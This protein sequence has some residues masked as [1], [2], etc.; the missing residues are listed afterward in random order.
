MADVHN[1]AQRSFNMSQIRCKNTTPEKI[2]RSFLF[3]HGFR[4]RINSSKLP[5]KPDIV[6]PKHKTVVLIHGCFWHGH[7]GCRYYV[8]PKSNSLFWR[9][10]ISGNKERDIRNEQKLKEDGWK[11]LVVWEC[12]LKPDKRNDTLKKL[13]AAINSKA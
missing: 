5:G 9:N 13:V 1:P 3:R 10:K 7:E 12:E 2:V 11:V 4:F 8:E 6:L